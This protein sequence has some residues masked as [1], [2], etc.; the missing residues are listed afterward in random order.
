[1]GQ[2]EDDNDIKIIPFHV[3]FLDLVFLAQIGQAHI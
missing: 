2:C 1:M 3:V